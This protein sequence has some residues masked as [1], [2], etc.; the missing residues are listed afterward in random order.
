MRNSLRIMVVAVAMTLMIMAIPTGLSGDLDDEMVI[1]DQQLKDV[2]DPLLAATNGRF[3]CVISVLSIVRNRKPAP[4]GDIVSLISESGG[5]FV[6]IVEGRTPGGGAGAKKIKDIGDQLRAVDVLGDGFQHEMTNGAVCEA[7]SAGAKSINC[8][9]ELGSDIG[10]KSGMRIGVHAKVGQNKD[11]GCWID[12][13]IKYVYLKNDAGQFPYDAL[14]RLRSNGLC[15]ANNHRIIDCVGQSCA[16]ERNI[17]DPKSKRI[18]RL[19]Y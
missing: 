11:S 14:E 3:R 17:V 1:S 18:K 10:G 5:W 2:C 6:D 8:G 9:S 16:L 13:R 7:I 19:H 12:A 4:G 15:Q